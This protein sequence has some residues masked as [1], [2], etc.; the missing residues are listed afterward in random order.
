MLTSGRRKPGIRFFAGIATAFEMSLAQVIIIA[1]QTKLR[2]KQ[3]KE[4]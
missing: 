2:E 3:D 1:E 4:E